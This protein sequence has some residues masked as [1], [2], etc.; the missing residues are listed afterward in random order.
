MLARTAVLIPALNEW[1]NIS[2]TMGY[3]EVTRQP[4][5]P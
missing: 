4:I 1:P 2:R 3:K 5:T